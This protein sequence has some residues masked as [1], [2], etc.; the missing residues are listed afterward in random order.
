MKGKEGGEE[1]SGKWWEVRVN[2]ENLVEGKEWGRRESK[3]VGP[4]VPSLGPPVGPPISENLEP[5]LTL[6]RL[7]SRQ[8]CVGASEGV[9]LQKN[10]WSWW[11]ILRLRL[12]K[13]ELCRRF[14]KQPS[15]SRHHSVPL[16]WSTGRWSI[17]V[18][19]VVLSFCSLSSVT[20]SKGWLWLTYN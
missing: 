1:G 11:R 4:P 2:E 19:A 8:L 14:K 12:K 17:F 9:C 3:S 6:R 7:V 20:V 18:V 5:P 10:R 15:S 16:C 13:F